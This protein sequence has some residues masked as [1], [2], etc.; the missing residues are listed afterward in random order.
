MTTDQ[1]KEYLQDVYSLET[2]SYQQKNLISSIR[3]EVAS[4]GNLEP[5][6]RHESPVEKSPAVTILGGSLL[7][8]GLGV[9]GWFIGAL[10]AILWSGV[11][12]GGRAAEPSNFIYKGGI[13]L[14]K[15]SVII[16]AVGLISLIIWAMYVH[17]Q[18]SRLNEEERKDYESRLKYENARKAYL[19]AQLLS[20]NAVH[21]KTAKTLEDMYNCNIIYPKYRGLVPVSCMTDYISSGICTEL[22]GPDGAYRMYEYE[23]Q[24]QRIVTSLEKILSCLEDIRSTMY[25]LYQCIRQSQKENSRLLSELQ[26]ASRRYAEDAAARHQEI[27]NIRKIEQNSA[28]LAKSME[29]L[30]KE[31]SMRNRMHDQGY[32]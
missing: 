30:Q 12:H 14:L 18:N 8:A 22:T 7:C 32:L 2:A 10:C 13:F 16:F 3:S 31:Y 17:K 29:Q 26:R 9:A 5:P 15:A 28:V 1:L 6:A 23:E 11:A 20:L 4:L 25:K 21:E 19:S 24:T 27:D